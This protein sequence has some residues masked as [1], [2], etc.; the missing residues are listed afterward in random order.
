MSD[1]HSLQGETINMAFAPEIN[2]WQGY[3][4]VQLRIVDLELAD[5]DSKLKTD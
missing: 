5:Q 3:E 4:R 2:A 1:R